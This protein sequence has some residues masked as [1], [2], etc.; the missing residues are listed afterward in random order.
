MVKEITDPAEIDQVLAGTHSVWGEGLSRHAFAS[1]VRAQGMTAW[2]QANLAR[3]GLVENGEIQVSAK[4][5]LFDARADGRP[6]KVL[7]IGAVFTPEER[8]GQGLASRLIDAMVEDGQARG[9]DVAILFSQIGPEFY[10]QKGFSVV[11]RSLLTIDVPVNRRGAPAVLVRAAE[12]I[13]L[14][15]LADMSMLHAGNAGFALTRTPALLEFGV[16]QRRLLAGLGPVGRRALEFFVT[17]EGHRAVAYV[18]ISHGPA[19]SVL[20]ECGDRD[21]SGARVGAML[22]VLA[23]REPSH[24]DRTLRTWWPETFR[25]PQIQVIG[26]VPCPDVM[27]VRVLN[28]RSPDFARTVYW[29]TDL[30]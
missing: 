29:Q 28:G 3:V 10:A 23:A 12:P 30:C 4:R 27:M 14:P 24:T 21:P 19:G 1:W 7:G 13:D 22:E 16:I 9:C 2:G 18:L 11:E 25:P 6:L 17:E 20:E 8:R 5:Y 26:S 15:L